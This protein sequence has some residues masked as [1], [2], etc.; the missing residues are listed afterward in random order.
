MVI[1]GH[2][3]GGQVVFNALAHTLTETLVNRR[4]DLEF[5]AGFADP[6]IASKTLP[7]T[8]LIK[9]F[10]DLVLL[11]NPAFEASRYYDLKTLSELFDYVP[12]QRPVMG[13][14]SS[15]TDSAT[16]VAF[17]IGRFFS[18][19]FERYRDDSLHDLQRTANKRTIPW[20]ESWVT[21]ELVQATPKAALSPG[22]RGTA[23]LATA[24]A[25]SM[26]Y[27]E[28]VITNWSPATRSQPITLGGAVLTPVQPEKKWTPFYVTRVDSSIINE[29]GG[30]WNPQ[31]SEF[32][33]EFITVSVRHD[34]RAAP[35]SKSTR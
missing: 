15:K 31:F 17:P 32:I 13:I 8:E 10:G 27:L 30:I 5:R 1:A 19:A 16:R 7:A 18:T 4:T 12:A 23:P 33:A 3:F 20:V 29:H 35:A 34:R 21:H 28:S 6:D 9:P 24:P 25:S 11:V 26:Q 22:V 2:S 14:F